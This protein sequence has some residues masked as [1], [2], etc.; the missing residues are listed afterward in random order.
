MVKKLK[1][2]FLKGAERVRLFAFYFSERFKVEVAVMKLLFR[3]DEVS[4]QKDELLKSIGLRVLCLRDHHDKEVLKD[5][6]VT[7]ALAAI[8]KL[9]QEIADLKE[10]IADLSRVTDS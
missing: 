4:R 7:E 6:E 2:N 8:A 3:S 1:D 9:D 10:K 5:R